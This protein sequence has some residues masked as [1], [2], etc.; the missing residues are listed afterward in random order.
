MS[1]QATRSLRSAT[2]ALARTSLRVP[3][4]S[5]SLLQRPMEQFFYGIMIASARVAHAVAAAEI[6]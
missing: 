2:S 4:G 6:H 1:R 3:S 5:P